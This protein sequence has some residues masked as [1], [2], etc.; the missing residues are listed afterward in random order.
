MNLAKS[1]LQRMPIPNQADPFAGYHRR[2]FTRLLTL[3]IIRRA[4]SHKVSA[5]QDVA[6]ILVFKVS[7]FPGNT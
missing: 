1:N 3:R 7:Q 4:L 5:L 2:A 6:T